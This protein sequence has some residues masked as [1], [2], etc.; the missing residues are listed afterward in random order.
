MVE[1]TYSTD[2]LTSLYPLPRRIRHS[3][4]FGSGHY[5]MH[6]SFHS[7]SVEARTCLYAQEVSTSRPY[8]GKQHRHKTKTCRFNHSSDSIM[9][10]AC[11]QSL[12]DWESSEIIHPFFNKMLFHLRGWQLE[13]AGYIFVDIKKFCERSINY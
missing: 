9:A 12:A 5:E 4:L 10:Q 1:T 6:A 2:H 8:S 11:E 13:E 3:P 7:I